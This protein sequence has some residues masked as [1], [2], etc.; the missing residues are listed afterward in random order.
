MKSKAQY[1]PPRQTVIYGYTRRMLDETNLNAQ[2]FSMSVAENYIA[3]TAPD[4]RH[5]PLQLGHGE[6]L[7][8]AMKNNAQTIRR[9][10]DGTVKTLP[11]DLEDAW[12]K[13]L[14][15]PYR[16]ECERDLARRRGM[17]MIPMPAD[18]ETADA[19]NLSNLAK[20]FGDLVH[21]L[22]PAL[23]D[24]HFDKNDLRHARKILNES[25]DLISAVLTLRRKATELLQEATHGR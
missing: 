4:V 25:D 7:C 13:S 8:H 2:S 24:G 19:E 18:G 23:A 17:L 14:P 9:Y 1:L 6:K 22:A 16:S 11:A 3:N 5:V 15:E 20:E 10:M 21:A 12:V